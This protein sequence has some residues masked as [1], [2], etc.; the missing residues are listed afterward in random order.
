[1][2]YLKKINKYKGWNQLN[3]RI[4]LNKNLLIV[5][6]ANKVYIKLIENAFNFF[7]VKKE[8]FFNSS[9]FFNK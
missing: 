2:N 7:F 5:T 8:K 3:N 1:M 9:L 6:K 4:E